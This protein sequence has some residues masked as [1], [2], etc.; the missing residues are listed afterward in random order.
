M[1]YKNCKNEFTLWNLLPSND[2]NHSFSA[3]LNNKGTLTFLNHRTALEMTM[4]AVI[5]AAL[6]VKKTGNHL[7][8]DRLSPAAKHQMIHCRQ[9]ASLHKNL[10]WLFQQY[11]NRRSASSG[12]EVIFCCTL[13]EVP[14]I[15][16][17]LLGF[18]NILDIVIVLCHG[19]LLLLR[20]SLIPSARKILR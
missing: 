9:G 7:V 12:S 6:E 13:L 4:L 8:D 3:I 10:P 14:F 19:P 11:A 16:F 5:S 2:Y 17:T 1:C 18:D 15:Q 20:Q